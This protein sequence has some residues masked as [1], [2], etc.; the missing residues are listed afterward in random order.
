MG[1]RRHRLAIHQAAAFRSGLCG[2][3]SAGRSG[4]HARHPSR[5]G[6]PLGAGCFDIQTGQFRFFQLEDGGKGNGGTFV[7]ADETNFFV[8]TRLRG[9]RIYD[10]KTGK[11][12]TFTL[13]EPVLTPEGYYSGQSSSWLQAA[14]LDA[15]QK[16]TDARQSVKDAIAD[17]AKADDEVVTNSFKKA[18]NALAKAEKKIA[19]AE[20]ALATA[21]RALSNSWAGNVI[22]S[23]SRGKQLR[24]ELRA[25]ASG[26]IIRAGRRLYAAGMNWIIAVELPKP[27]GSRELYGQATSKAAS[28]DFWRRTESYLRSRWTV[29]SWLSAAGPERRGQFE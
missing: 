16:L 25:D 4:R 10:L 28:C 27:G 20:L 11:K 9:T 21:K 12:G 24:W 18:T 19:P 29:G 1:Q 26:D 17:V 14:V 3:C 7:A 13:N 22:Q 2:R 5:S 15:E 8:H 23:V 6:R